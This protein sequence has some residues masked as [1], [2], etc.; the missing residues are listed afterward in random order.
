MAHRILVVDDESPTRAVLTRL[1]THAGHD[2]TAVPSVPQAE[3]LLAEDPPDLLI[4]DVRVATYNG[5]QLIAMAPTRCA[6]IVITGFVDSTIEADARRLGAECLFKPV[7]SATLYATVDRSLARQA[8]RLLPNQRR[9]VRTSLPNPLPVSGAGTTG[10]LLAVS[11]RGARLELDTAAADM[12]SDSFTFEIP[13]AGVSVVA[14]IA[15]KRYYSDLITCGVTI[16]PAS[17]PMWHAFLASLPPQ[18]AQE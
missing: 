14:N 17:L 16:T 2:V 11:E 18:P 4:T 12:L 7:S 5:L 3:V 15:W 9:E 6:A 13:S 10:R 8:E 1:L